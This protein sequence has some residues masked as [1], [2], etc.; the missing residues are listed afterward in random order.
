MT[1]TA[2]R[3]RALFD[4]LKAAWNEF[5]RDYARY[6]AGAIVYYALISLV[7]LVLLLLAGI[8]LLLRSSELAADTAQQVLLT[9]ETRFGE[10]LRMTIEQLL[11]GLQQGSVTATVI[12]LVGLLLAASVLFRHLRMTFRAIWKYVPPLASGSL[13]SIVGMTL[14]ERA[15][16]FAMVIGGGLMLLLLFVLIAALNWLGGTL[17]NLPLLGYASGW[18]VA[19]VPAL[20][21]AP[22]T[23]GL[24]FKFLPPTQLPWRHVWLAAVLCGG[25]WIIGAEILA[26]YGN[27]F[28]R[29]FGAYGALGTVLIVML[30]MKAVS[31]L[32]FFGAELCKVIAWRAKGVT[33]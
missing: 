25:A 30:W 2:R 20:L 26:I 27:F 9:I 29:N 32:L 23:F 6:F 14:V 3:A 31:T 11:D 10:P 19:L 21:I 28:G 24:L 33:G 1:Q 13:R 7:P 15:I 8:G 16:S 4:L 17:S 18:L 5:Q 22:L 12:S